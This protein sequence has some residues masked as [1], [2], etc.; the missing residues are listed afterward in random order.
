VKKALLSLAV[1]GL[2]LSVVQAAQAANPL[3]GGQKLR[4]VFHPPLCSGAE[5]GFPISEAYPASTLPFNPNRLNPSSFC[6]P[7]QDN[8]QWCG[9]ELPT[10]TPN[11]TAAPGALALCSQNVSS[12]DF[13]QRID[14]NKFTT[15]PSGFGN[16]FV[17]SYRLTKEIPESRKC[18]GI[19]QAQKF[20]Q[21][22]SGIRTWWTLIY[23]S[24]GTTFTLE[25]TV[26]CVRTALPN[27]VELHID[28]WRWRVVVTFESL[29]RVID[30][31]HSNSIGTSEIPC[32]AAENLY[33]AL[34]HSVERIERAF[35]GLAIPPPTSPASANNV[36]ATSDPIQR[37]V[38]AQNEIFN[39]EALVI[40][41]CAFG[42]CFDGVPGSTS[43]GGS[44]FPVF[45]P[46]ND[47]QMSFG[48]MLTGILDT[49]ENPCCCKL[50]VDIER[51]AEAYGII[52]L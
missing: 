52:S 30:V 28:R 12:S 39:M 37:R 48:G 45:P 43:P 36:A 24:P 20:V 42:D 1:A 14:I 13:R 16:A 23:T 50:L 49:P 40:A 32:I 38:N 18:P 34:K 10:G 26:R 46:S 19:Y 9:A 44:F 41:F 4:T 17:Q 25:V 15:C 31:L 27:D 11:T 7:I 35:Q 2:A 21:F 33:I 47:T 22:G 8:R 6:L 51:L 29:D 5:F 3:P